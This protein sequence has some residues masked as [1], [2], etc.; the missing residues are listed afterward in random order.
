V[1]VKTA[2]SQ[3]IRVVLTHRATLVRQLTQLGN[4]VR[5]TLK[6]FGLK[7]GRVTRA[8]FAQRVRELTAERPVLR[9][10]SLLA[11]RAALLKQLAVLDTYLVRTARRDAVC[12]RLMTVPGVGALTYRTAVDVPERFAKSSAIAAHFGLTPRLYASGETEQAGGITK[13]GDRMVRH[14]LFEAANVP[15]DASRRRPLAEAVGPADRRAA[16]CQFC[17]RRRRRQARGHP[18]SDLARRHDLYGP[19]GC[20][21]RLRGDHRIS[22]GRQRASRGDAR[23]RRK[24]CPHPA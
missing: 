5:D 21:R 20:G 16:R 3:E 23:K 7:L 19:G 2:R 11:V 14:H 12:R 18:P 1:H 9:Q 17:P 10:A 4:T 13:R 15:A 8:G 6:T 24:V 22:A